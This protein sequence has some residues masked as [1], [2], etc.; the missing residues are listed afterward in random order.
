MCSRLADREGVPVRDVLVA[1]ASR[2]TTTLNAYVSGFGARGV[3]SSTTTW[4]TTCRA[5]RWCRWW[6]TSSPTPSTVTWWSDPALGAVGAL[7]GVGLLGLV[8]GRGPLR[9]RYGAGLAAGA[10]TVPLVIA[11]VDVGSLLASP[12]QNGIS[13]RIETRADVDALKATDD[14]VA[15]EA[16]QL[17]LARRSLSDPTPPALSQWWFGSHP[18][19]LE[20]IG[21]AR[22]FAVAQQEVEPRDAWIESQVSWKREP[23]AAAEGVRSQVLRRRAAPTRPA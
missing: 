2:R 7:A 23:H 15:F 6:P 13:R 19:T 4:S 17:M 1:D 18:T 20:R 9:R 22:R 5:T 8:V 10:V 3:S 11:L 16:M 12:V 14:P 21:V